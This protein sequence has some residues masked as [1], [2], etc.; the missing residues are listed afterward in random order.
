VEPL[1]A[2]ALLTLATEGAWPGASE[3][4]TAPAASSVV[5]RVTSSAVISFAVASFAALFTTASSAAL[6][7]VASLSGVAVVTAASSGTAGPAP[8]SCRNRLLDRPPG[9]HCGYLPGR[10]HGLLAGRHHDRDHH[11]SPLCTGA[12]LTSSSV[13]IVANSAVLT[14]WFA[15]MGSQTVAGTRSSAE[16]WS[17]VSAFKLATSR[18]ASRLDP[19]LRS[20][21]MMSFT[22]VYIHAGRC[23][24]S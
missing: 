1:G 16:N 15:Q 23:N 11:W 10:L 7:S 14:A 2:T 21:R 6:L 22:L 4:P 24:W 13:G 17:W 8:K 5:L 20:S 18:A 12:M 3:P 9:R 19:G